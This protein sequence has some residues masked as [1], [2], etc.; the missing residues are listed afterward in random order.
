[1]TV[2][3]LED[4]LARSITYRFLAR[5]WMREL[6]LQALHDIC[7]GS[8]STAFAAAGGCVPSG[9]SDQILHQLN[10]EYC[11]H[12]LGPTGHLPPYQSVWQTGQFQSHAT[13]SMRSFMEIGGYDPDSV[14]PGMMLDH[15]GVQLDMMS[16]LLCQFQSAIEA[17]QQA[18]VQEIASAYYD[19]HL[20]WSRH[21]LHAAMRRQASDFYHSVFQLTEDFLDSETRG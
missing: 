8:L 17:G 13:D 18:V 19:S 10:A 1:M 21:L 6:D 16:H 14:Q 20:V 2:I 15:F 5:L 4:A 3:P 9:A 7:S 12:F 11:G